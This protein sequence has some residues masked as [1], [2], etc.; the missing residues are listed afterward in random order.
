MRLRGALDVSG[1]KQKWVPSEQHERKRVKA[2]KVTSGSKIDSRGA[3]GGVKVERRLTFW[4]NPE[5]K[6][7]ESGMTWQVRV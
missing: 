4:K 3:G 2:R 5:A 1:V 7:V 6:E